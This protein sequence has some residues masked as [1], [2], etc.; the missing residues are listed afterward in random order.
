MKRYAVVLEVSAQAEYVDHMT[1]V[2][3]FGARE[4]PDDGFMNCAQQFQNN[5]A[6]YLKAFHLRRKMMSSSK[7]FVR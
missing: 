5:S 6:S 4:R 1:G 2:A 3:E 7:K